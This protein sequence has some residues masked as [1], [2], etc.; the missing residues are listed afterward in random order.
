[1]QNNSNT[2]SHYTHHQKIKSPTYRTSSNDVIEASFQAC[3]CT[4]K[5]ESSLVHGYVHIINTI[6]SKTYKGDKSTSFIKL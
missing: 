6:Q 5:L 1:M 2:H 4:G 3:L